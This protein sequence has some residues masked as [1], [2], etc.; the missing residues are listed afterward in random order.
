MFEFARAIQEE[1]RREANKYRLAH[2]V[3][4]KHS[5]TAGRSRRS[6]AKSPDRSLHSSSIK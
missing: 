3:S 6:V 1:R 5:R 2:S 4:R